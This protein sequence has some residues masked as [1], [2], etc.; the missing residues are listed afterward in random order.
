MQTLIC[1]CVLPC[2]PTSHLSGEAMKRLAVPAA[3]MFLLFVAGSFLYVQLTKAFDR[4]PCCVDDA[5]FSIV[6]KNLALNGSYSRPYSSETLSLFDPDIGV[7]PALI[8]PGAAMI[9]LVGAKPWA[10]GLTTILLFTT[11]LTLMSM[12]LARRFQLA[13]VFLYL[14]LCLLALVAITP[15]QDVYFAFIGEGPAFGYLI[16]GSVLLAT[17]RGRASWVLMSALSISLALLT[18]HIALFCALGAAGTW[19][20]R[21]LYLN[22]FRALALMGVFLV[23]IA[24]PLVIFELVKLSVLGVSGY[25]DHWHGYFIVFNL[26]HVGVGPWSSKDRLGEVLAVLQRPYVVTV[27]AA[28][29]GLASLLL[30]ALLAVRREW[31]TDEPVF[32]LML[33]GGAIVYLLYIIFISDLTARYFWLGMAMSVFA[34]MSPILF[35]RF[36]FALAAAVAGLA[37]VATPRAVFY[38]YRIQ[39]ALADG[40]LAHEREIVLQEIANHPDLPIVSQWWPTIYDIVYMLND[41]HPWYM[42]RDDHPWHMTNDQHA[43]YMTNDVQRVPTLRALFITLDRFSLKDDAFYVQV[44]QLCE[45]VHPELKFYEVFVCSG[46]AD[47]TPPNPRKKFNTQN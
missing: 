18:K 9:A 28:L 37:F 13:N 39:L 17:S 45:R 5:Y 34:I 35:L 10:G 23:G 6:A 15:R 19:F 33:F 26:H 20:L 16:V 38:A 12:L 11:T 21:E 24:G 29:F 4:T 46:G 8:V 14:A 7:G 22:R 31:R 36:R 25:L 27:R 43:A 2:G 44:H 32:G 41:N 30:T 42:T 3:L 1:P 47:T 40:R